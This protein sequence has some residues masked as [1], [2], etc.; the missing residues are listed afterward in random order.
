[1]CCTFFSVFGALFLFSVAAMMRANYRYVHI[2]ASLS[3]TD[4]P[5]LSSSV[6]YAAM[7]YLIMGL[8]AMCYWSK[9]NAAKRDAELA[10]QVR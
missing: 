4:L 8:V 2:D 6:S 1:M 10:A 7:L 3:G 9:G 5:G